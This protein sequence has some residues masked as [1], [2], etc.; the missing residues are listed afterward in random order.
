MPGTNLTRAE[1]QDR[2]AI[3]AT[4]SYVVK[5]DLTTSP[6]TFRSVT[7]VR[8]TATPGASSFIDLIARSV[9]AIT[10]NGESLDPATHFADSRISLPDLAAANELVVDATCAYMN[11]GEGL[12]RF[13]DPVDNEVYLYTQFE[14]PDSRRIMAVFEQPDLKATFAFS[15]TGPDHWQVVSNAITPQPEPA[16]PGT[17]TW[18]F[19]AT[20]RISSYITALVAGPYAVVRDSVQTRAGTIDLGVF[21]RTSM[22]P[23]LDADN[24]LAVTKAGFGFFEEMFDAPY[25]F[26]KYDQLFTPE[27]N[28]GA[29]ENAGCVTI[30]ELYVFRGKVPDSTVE[31]RALT[32]LHELA[33]MWFGDLVTMKWWDDLWLNES[34]AEWASTVCQAEA[35]EWQ[36]AW[37]T[38]CT[39]EKA[40]AYRQDQLSSTHPIVAPIRDLHDVEVNF[41]GIT[42]AKGA[43]A[44]RQLV[45]FVGIE[46]FLA[47][48]RTYFARH[49]WGNTQLS[50]LLR[51]LEES[52]GRDLAFFTGQ[53]LQTA[54]VNTLT[55]E[56]ELDERGRFTRFAVVQHAPDQWPTL[57]RHRIGI[58]LYDPTDEGIERVHRVEL[59]IDGNRTEVPALV[60]VPA[61]AVVLLNDGDLSYAKIRIDLGLDVVVD[62]IHEFRDPVARA[63]LWGATWDMCRDA[64]LTASDYVD[65]VVRGVAVETDL[66]AVTAVLAQAETAVRYYTPTHQRDGIASRWTAGLVRLL[67]DA[68]PGS[69]HQLA[70]VRALATSLTTPAGADLLRAWLAGEEVPAGLIVDTD[71]RWRLVTQLAQLGGLDDAGIAAELARDNTATGAEKAAGARAAR[72]DDEAKAAAWR[73]AIEDPSVPNATHTQICAYFWAPDQEIVLKPYVDAWFGVMG[74]I[75]A[76][77]NGWGQRSLAIRKNVGELLFPRPFGDPALV[78]RIDEWMAETELTD[79]VRR[80]VSERRDDVERALRCQQAATELAA[81]DG[82]HR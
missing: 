55:S 8:F 22:L 74:D 76:Q 10:L 2:A 75:A 5:L 60:G 37:T 25:P 21:C 42:Y 72:P 62:R 41:D 52:S 15:V 1:A 30:N 48:V 12:H 23:H 46:P 29:M 66:T 58:G 77:R 68:D 73:L 14:V 19:P 45:A 80:M 4:E 61:P 13:V 34:F 20:G 50:D 3:V 51:A 33:H 31:R 79:S 65:L 40:W 38:F 7:T 11:T 59:D 81:P 9:E 70:L 43:S 47:G 64:Q 36:S 82:S 44:L 63:L 53:W 32:I 56:Y 35:T 39:H 28:M 69:D 54:G 57:R 24:V 6:E 26:T 17:A 18:T 16:G 27:Y 78:A 49:G 67:K 71:L